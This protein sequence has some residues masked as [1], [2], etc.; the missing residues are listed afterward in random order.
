MLNATEC[1]LAFRFLRAKR[2]EG[3][4]SVIAVFSFLGI[5]LGVGTLIV[6]MA[7]FNGFRVEITNY[8]LGTNAHITLSQPGGQHI[9]NYTNLAEQL[10]QVTGVISATPVISG[11]VLGAANGEHTGV[12]VRG[13]TRAD[14]QARPMIS[15]NIVAGSLG[16]L[17]NESVMLGS[18]LAQRLGLRVGETIQLISPQVSYS[19]LGAMPRIKTYTVAAIVE[20]GM[21]EYDNILV[22]MPMEAAQLY[23]QMRTPRAVSEIEIMTENPQDAPQIAQNMA[24]TLDQPYYLLD[25]Q[26]A[27]AHFLEKLKVERVTMFFIMTFIILIAAFNILSGLVMMVIDKQKEI[28]ILRT[29]G[30]TRRAIMRIFL[31]IGLSIG[32]L[33]TLL[34]VLLGVSF[35]VNIDTIRLWLE[36]LTDTP[37][38]AAEAYFLSKLPAVFDPLHVVITVSISLGLSFLA[39]LYPAWKASRLEPVEGLHYE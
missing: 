33:G 24:T 36:H 27:N 32:C 29:M 12:V 25:W 20:M 19:I 6:V 30:M 10:E 23:F 9:N 28:A 37:I 22:Y 21:Y 13:M 5:M 7:V 34:G 11:Q 1:M 39:T 17:D 26:T 31:L 16:V 35:A 4:I 15:E 8:I 3:F 18:R 2:K 38:F 14:L